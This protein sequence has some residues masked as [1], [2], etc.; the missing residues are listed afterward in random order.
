MIANLKFPHV[1]LKPGPALELPP[2]VVHVW[3]IRMDEPALPIGEFYKSLAEDERQ[4]AAAMP[5]EAGERY[6]CCHGLLRWILARYC[7]DD[8]ASLVFTTD[9]RGKPH[10]ATIP[11][12][13]LSFNLAHNSG[14]AIVGVTSGGEIG[15]DVEH[16]SRWE[17]IEQNASEVFTPEELTM[18]KALPDRH[19]HNAIVRGWVR[20]EALLK[21]AGHGLTVRLSDL[22]V[23][24]EHQRSI[25]VPG[26]DTPWRLIDLQLPDENSA[27]AVAVADRDEPIEVFLRH[28]ADAHKP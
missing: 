26:V 14:L 22:D 13:K 19:R 6:V 8:A 25:H 4:R 28:W 15:V 16:R 12:R 20:K 7:G 9:L 24:T 2:G 10:L 17:E 27:A 5:S 23:L 18:L 3:W 21:A 1:E 11:N